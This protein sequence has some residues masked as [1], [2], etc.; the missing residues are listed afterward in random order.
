MILK[1]LAEA[2]WEQDWIAVL[3]EVLIVVVGIFVGVQVNDWNE[4]RK[5]KHEEFVYLERIIEDFAISI[6]ETSEK[7]ELQER[8]AERAAIVLDALNEQDR[9]SMSKPSSRMTVVGKRWA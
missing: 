9:W 4:D 5:V 3:L 8:H 1:R 7:I 6:R 2:F